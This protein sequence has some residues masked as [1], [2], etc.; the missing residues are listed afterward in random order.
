MADEQEI[1][2]NKKVIVVSP[3]GKTGTVPFGQYE[4][5]KSKGY[6]AATKEE[7]DAWKTKK[8]ADLSAVNSPL[9]ATALPEPKGGSP[10]DTRPF[11]EADVEKVMRSTKVSREEAV[12]SA[13]NM[14]AARE[15]PHA[16]QLEQ[17][18]DYDRAAEWS[19]GAPIGTMIE[20]FLGG[21]SVNMIPYLEGR[22]GAT[23]EEYGLIDNP[24]TET[25]QRIRRESNPTL[26]TT[27]EV[28]GAIAP[29]LATAGLSTGLIA[30]EGAAGLI[31]K[32]LGTF[33]IGSTITQ[34][35]VQAA[36]RKILLSQKDREIAKQ[37]AEITFGKAAAEKALI[38]EG[39]A[40][41]ELAKKVAA[42]K[43]SAAEANAARQAQITGEFGR[44]VVKKELA[45]GEEQVLEQMVRRKLEEN[46]ISPVVKNMFVGKMSS[47]EQ[48]GRAAQ[49]LAA[50][51]T[52][53]A[54]VGAAALTN[55]EI[56][57]MFEEASK[58]DVDLVSTDFAKVAWK[59]LESA[60]ERIPTTLA[61]A[62]TLGVASPYIAKTLGSA[63][64][65]VNN[66]LQFAAEKVPGLK[67]PTLGRI[68]TTA[69]STEIAEAM[70]AGREM[71]KEQRVFTP[72]EV[73]EALQREY[74]AYTL[75]EDH[76][77][78]KA[79]KYGL[80]PDDLFLFEQ[81]QEI[82]SKMQQNWMTQTKFGWKYDAKKVES[83]L[84]STPKIPSTEEE[85]FTTREEKVPFGF[86][87]TTTTKLRVTPNVEA[88]ESF[89][90]G[91]PPKYQL[92]QEISD[93]HNIQ[94]SLA[95][96]FDDAYLN[97]YAADMSD[98]LE[99]PG[100]DAYRT[101]QEIIGK[102]GSWQTA[103][104]K[105][106]MYNEY[107]TDYAREVERIKNGTRFETKLGPAAQAIGVLA[108]P[109][110]GGTIGGGM[111]AA[112]TAGAGIPLTYLVTT[113]FDPASTINTLHAFDVASARSQRFLKEATNSILYS[114]VG[115][116][117]TGGAAKVILQTMPKDKTVD[118]LYSEKKDFTERMGMTGNQIDAY[119]KIFGPLDD[120]SPTVGQKSKD[121]LSSAFAYLNTKLP[122][123]PP[124]Q[125][126][127][128][129]WEPT[130]KQ[131]QEFIRQYEYAQDP[132]KIV[133]DIAD[134]GV[135]TDDQMEI[136]NKVHGNFLR[137]WR[138]QILSDLVEGQK[139]GKTLSLQELMRTSKIMGVQPRDA[140]GFSA[141]DLKA[142]QDVISAPPTPKAG[143]KV[144]GGSQLEATPT[145]ERELR[146]RQN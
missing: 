105:A 84:K 52:Q 29:A 21:A 74:D 55:V 142:M 44:N 77:V 146:K 145:Q 49:Q 88:M 2:P 131:K 96:Q 139:E 15:D 72:S 93:F 106:L 40:G 127:N 81:L 120:N 63:V 133:T 135:A 11:D 24:F 33:D 123:P 111:V 27:S 124:N 23:L 99:L 18:R 125:P 121:T 51:G 90:S 6:R 107:Y 132:E 64:R 128:V 13:K 68:G 85:F 8:A 16:P 39:K 17:N 46:A 138:K 38:E 42:G 56:A 137:S 75:M 54:G 95:D 14:K 25:R 43:I 19:S 61:I 86:G 126:L 140:S 32:G 117:T 79:D 89:V 80:N 110:L 62:G 98:E 122:K 1:D 36:T 70:R 104:Q 82:K 143:G 129:K 37:A 58:A 115:K 12:R 83:H 22:L 57:N 71:T 65:G 20:R 114:K 118:E 136:L 103:E 26:A 31:A 113:A 48:L 53:L 10:E 73:V 66:V 91:V 94:N 144:G 50:K 119:N 101:T 59:S 28:I 97:K 116:T 9:P 34:K 5:A 78:K 45:K 4:M 76:L 130:R 134:S 112:K 100:L 41:V 30:E 141:A 102:F 69:T 109:I 35:P 108:P 47:T 67:V 3:D 87:S 7:G 60:P 92:P